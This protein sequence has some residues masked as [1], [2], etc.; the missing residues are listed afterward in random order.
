MIDVQQKSWKLKINW[1]F[2]LINELDSFI[3]HTPAPQELCFLKE[4]D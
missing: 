3:K 1:N 4:A 2:R